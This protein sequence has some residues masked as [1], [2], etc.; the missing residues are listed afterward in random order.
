MSFGWSRIS[1]PLATFGTLRSAPRISLVTAG[2]LKPAPEDLYIPS[3]YPHLVDM[4]KREETPL[5]AATLQQT[6]PE[7]VYGKSRGRPIASVF[8]SF[9]LHSNKQTKAH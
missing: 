5:F 9:L 1:A 8:V 3:F 2:Y 6:A 4:A 7:K